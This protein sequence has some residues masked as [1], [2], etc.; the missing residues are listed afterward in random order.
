[1]EI[2]SYNAVDSILIPHTSFNMA[3]QKI[4][5]CFRVAENTLE[6]IC[7]ALIGE[8][9]AGKTRVLE[10]IEGKYPKSRTEDGM[11][12]PVLRL[13][14]PARPTIKGFAEEILSALGDPTPG[15][16]TVSNMTNR[17]VKLVRDVETRMIMVDEFQHF[18][19]KEQHRVMHH[20]AD[21]FKVL[22]DRCKVALVVSG[23]PSSQ[24]VLN[25]NEQLAGRFMSPIRIPRFD[26]KDDELRE[27]FIGILEAFDSGLKQ[28]CFPV[29]DSDEMS[30]RF[31]CA[32]GGLIGYLAKIL[33]QAVWNSLDND[34]NQITLDDLAIAYQE[35][36]YKD[37]KDMGL[38]NPF[39]RGF[40]VQENADLLKRISLIGIA[41]PKEQKTMRSPRKQVVPSP[42]DVLHA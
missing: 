41:K 38:P 3:T 23:L 4:M 27:E 40:T 6:P 7:L 42:S 11:H 14:T 22:V 20:V 8:S 9:R 35:S 18:Y 36:V 17:I 30:F 34:M 5:Q 32:T 24:F 25:L 10:H 13:T 37:E 31:Y 28:F 29:L 33:R 15:K 21:W 26:W 16:G 12:I 19:D 1:M 2:K 39:D